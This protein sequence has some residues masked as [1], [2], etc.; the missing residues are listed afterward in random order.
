MYNGSAKYKTGIYATSRMNKGRVT[1]DVSDVTASGD[2]ASIITTSE[3][4][5]SVKAQL[6]NKVRN[7]TNKTATLEQDRFKLDGSFSFADDTLSNNGEL[8]WSSAVIC[9]SSG[10]FVQT[11]TTDFSGKVS[12]SVVENANKAYIPNATA[13]TLQSPSSGNWFEMVEW[14]PDAK[15]SLVSSLDGQLS[16][17]GGISSGTIGQELFSF[18]LKDYM[19]RNYGLVVDVPWLKA[20][21]KNVTLNW[22]GF[23]SSSTGNKAYL[24]RWL[25][26]GA[27]QN[28]SGWTHTSSAIS[29]LTI[30]EGDAPTLEIGRASCRERVL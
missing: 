16:S 18:D 13:T 12:G 23:G 14:H 3:S 25:T 2:V 24:G 29:K 11:G 27:W 6:I 4:P 30:A 17:N 7:S 15:Y 21:V 10:N 19:L 28:V 26:S 5:L 9:D 22:W 1:F 20:N 8:G